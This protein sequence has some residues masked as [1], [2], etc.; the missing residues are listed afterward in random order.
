ML[1]MLLRQKLAFPHSFDSMLHLLLNALDVQW[2]LGHSLGTS[3]RLD[4]VIKN[5]LEVQGMEVGE[6]TLEAEAE[7]EAEADQGMCF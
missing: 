6:Q 7:R 3:L 4:E 1:L 2:T 5:V